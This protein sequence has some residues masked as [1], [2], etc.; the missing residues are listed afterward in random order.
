MHL[1]NLGVYDTAA[2]LV[3]FLH[4][5]SKSYVSIFHHIIPVL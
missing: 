2:E 3:A 5:E 4:T 1:F